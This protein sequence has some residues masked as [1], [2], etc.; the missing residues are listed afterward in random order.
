M[1]NKIWC[2]M[3][4]FNEWTLAFVATGNVKQKRENFPS[5]SFFLHFSFCQNLGKLINFLFSRFMIIFPFLF[6]LPPLLDTSTYGILSFIG[7]TCQRLSWTSC[8][9]LMCETIGILRDG[10]RKKKIDFVFVSWMGEWLAWL[11]NNYISL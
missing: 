8:M 5:F 6:Y 2:G 9:L 3:E 10:K 1:N 4:R 7:F 11:A